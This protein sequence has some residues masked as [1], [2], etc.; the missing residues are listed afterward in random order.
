MPS[1][2]QPPQLD[3]HHP[4]SC[5]SASESAV[6]YRASGETQRGHGGS[7]VL[8]SLE[9]PSRFV[10]PLPAPPGELGPFWA[11]WCQ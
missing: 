8:G 11:L 10:C 7:V 2:I 4:A 1:P 6:T 3:G 5:I 9:A